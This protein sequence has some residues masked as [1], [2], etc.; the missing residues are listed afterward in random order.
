MDSKKPSAG[1][2]FPAMSWEAVSGG[3]I[4]PVAAAGWRALIVYRGKHCPLCKTYLNSLDQMLEEF[5][6]AGIAVFALSADPKEKAEAE[7]AE[8]GWRFPVGYGLSVEQMRELGLYIS[9]PRSPQE[10]D[11]PFAEPGLF[12]INSD[13]NIQIVDISNAPFARPDLKSLLKGIQFVA[14]KSYPIRGLA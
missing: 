6:S 7:V 1:L 14:S 5:R 11:R 3:R 9:D 8:C 2:P 12:V 13:G 10:T 4:D